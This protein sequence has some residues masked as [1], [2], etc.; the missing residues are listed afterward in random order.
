MR[1]C[2]YWINEVI[3]VL[4]RLTIGSDFWDGVKKWWAVSQE[5][6]WAEISHGL[7]SAG[8][9]ARR[10][11]PGREGGSG[12]L[13]FK[14]FVFHSIQELGLT[15]R[16]WAGLSLWFPYRHL[17]VNE[18]FKATTAWA[19]KCSLWVRPENRGGRALWLRYAPHSPARGPGWHAATHQWLNQWAPL[20]YCLPMQVTSLPTPY[21]A[22]L[23]NG[24]KSHYFIGAMRTN[25]LDKHGR[26]HPFRS[27]FVVYCF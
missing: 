26:T 20:L 14:G 15:L 4:K 2:E 3:Y 7:G 10:L 12:H 11:G 9:T 16:K 18:T 8:A 13:V 1:L 19:E 17:V 24:E 27:Q 6:N 23:T 22:H 5:C 25:H 21:I